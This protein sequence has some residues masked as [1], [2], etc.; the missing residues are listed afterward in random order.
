MC[1]RH[2]LTFLEHGL[3]PMDRCPSE[4]ADACSDHDLARPVQLCQVVD[5]DVD[6][7]QHWIRADRIVDAQQVRKPAFLEVAGDCCVVDVSDAVEIEEADVALDPMGVVV[8][9][10]NQPA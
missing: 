5:R 2:A 3:L 1:L 7:H 4:L 6:K 10:R 9:G 8:E